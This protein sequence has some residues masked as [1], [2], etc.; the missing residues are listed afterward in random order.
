MR[1]ARET[2]STRARGPSVRS[3]PPRAAS[4]GVRRRSAQTTGAA[5]YAGDCA[6]FTGRL[7]VCVGVRRVVAC[8]DGGIGARIDGAVGSVRGG[9]A[10]IRIVR[11]REACIG[12]SCVYRPLANVRR[13]FRPRGVLGGAAAA[14]AHNIEA[15]Y[16]HSKNSEQPRIAS[17]K[18]RHL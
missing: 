6:R 13:T 3:A 14:A 12:M 11:G 7:S 2:T 8:V 10:C 15:E 18:T 1:C 4:S 17:K 5:L 9:I 16:H